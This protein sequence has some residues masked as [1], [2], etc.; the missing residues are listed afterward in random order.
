[1]A[2]GIT[3]RRVRN[4]EEPARNSYGEMWKML[5]I[6]CESERVSFAFI[7]IHNINFWIFFRNGDDDNARETKT[8]AENP[9]ESL[10]RVVIVASKK[11]VRATEK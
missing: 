9:S 7:A 8:S 5:N 3:R 11:R 10:S 2:R 6:S 1:M 4:Y